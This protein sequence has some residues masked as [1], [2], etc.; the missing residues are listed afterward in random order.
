[1]KRLIILFVISLLL[2]ALPAISSA[3]VWTI[4]S[5]D[6]PK[7]FTNFPQRAI[8]IDSLNRPH[9]V[10]GEYELYHAWFDGSQWHS[11]VVDN[12]GGG[13]F[14]S[15]AID[16]N[17]KIHISYR[18]NS[19]LKYATNASGSWVSSVIDDSAY[20]TSIAVDSNN[21]V[22]IGYGIGG[23]VY[24]V[25]YATNATG[26]WVISDVDIW[27]GGFVSYR[28]AYISIAIDSNNKAHMSYFNNY[29][30]DL[31]YATNA[32]GSWVTS[33]IDWSGRVGMFT[34]IAV[35]SNDKMHIS[36]YK[37]IS[38]NNYGLMYATNAS[39]S[40]VM[41]Q[42]YVTVYSA[43]SELYS[44][45][46]IDSNNKIHISHWAGNN[47]DLNYIT[48]ASGSWVNTSLDTNGN[49][50]AY[51]SIA[52]DSNNKIHISYADLTNNDLK[53]ATNI[54]GS[55][56]MLAVDSQ[57]GAGIAPSMAIDSNDKMHISYYDALD[58]DIKYATNASGLWSINTIDSTG[59]VVSNS[60]IA[61]D[62]NNKIHISYY[63]S[64]NGDLKYAT[65]ASGS[66]V[67]STIDSVWT[68]GRY[69]S[70]AIDS[71]NKVHI[72]YY[73]NYNYDL[74][75]ATNTS[76]SW[77][78]STIDS[79][80]NVGNY[81]SIA[82]DSNNKV[83]ISSYDYTNDDLKYATN[84]SGSW[85][86][87]IINSSVCSLCQNE[88]EEPLYNTSIALDSNNKAHVSYQ[89]TVS[90][91]LHY[92]TNA[93]GSWVTS[94]IYN[95]SLSWHPK[96]VASSIGIDSNNKVHISFS[97]SYT[98]NLKYA[99][100]VTGSWGISTVDTVSR[101]NALVLD[102]LNRVKIAYSGEKNSDDLKY[103]EIPFAPVAGTWALEQ[104]EYSGSGDGINISLRDN[105]T[106]TDN[107]VIE[108]DVYIQPDG[109][110]KNAFII[111]DYQSP[112]DFK[113][114][115]VWDSADR[116][117]IGYYNG[118]WNMLSTFLEP[119]DTSRWYRVRVEINGNSVTLYVDDDRDGSGFIY[120]TE[121]TFTDIG[122]G[123]VGLATVDSHAHFDNFSVYWDGDGDGY[124]SDVDCNDTDPLE[125][126]DQIWFLDADDDG[127][128]D[129][130]T[131]TTSCT[132]P[133]YYKAAS[134]L[135]EL[136]GDCDDNDPDISPATPWYP[137]FD[138]DGYGNPTISLQQC[139]QPAGY[140]L[141]N[142][143][144]DDNDA[145]I[146]PGGPPVRI[147]RI[148]PAYYS[149][150]QSA[151]NAAV[152]GETIQSQAVNFTETLNFNA[153]KSM[154]LQGGYD[155][156]YASNTNETIVNG[157]M[158]I[159]NGAVTIENLVVQ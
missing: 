1:M 121:A 137:D 74:K 29:N 7:Y 107:I 70:I 154:V 60:S 48:N 93:S 106:T 157:T 156:G 23:T 151:Y 100:N 113:Y 21:K 30:E 32:S 3:N 36:Y 138:S 97:D 8:A 9:I 66:W 110:S 14:A 67:I 130:T 119:I 91:D 144:C 46:G 117:V 40:W 19:K 44:S 120:K 108:T 127:Y 112:T 141:N 149:T 146:Y 49:V 89:T 145:N 54:S 81:S 24:N 102:S 155:C 136:S 4:E 77:V 128:S 94:I 123:A 126:P 88:E 105:F 133:L 34:S 148:T 26:S 73:D 20:S 83:Y 17:N 131:N 76:G 85:V 132:R 118:S 124:L 27:S 115:D 18:G 64:T 15:I 147:Y 87:E 72:S 10:Y 52:V 62:S 59:Y 98:A 152:D 96:I 82:V 45:I 90:N 55:W 71:N 13:E 80:G 12:S 56:A 41:S 140:V 51:N 111:F 61:L 39:G 92:S 135:I 101:Y 38:S 43:Y 134:E 25:R 104:N 58:Q 16:S 69:N 153:N 57:Q 103:A 68:V 50:G 125:H 150:L 116:W 42:L 53:Y 5:I 47:G 65:N 129:G 2:S 109:A 22:H 139:T 122:T 31:K 35:D 143:D 99:T 28:D 6:H 95:G 11:E 86:I 158:T 33:V 78:V 142:T 114:V 37:Y 79:L 75:Y 84:A 63:D 159:S